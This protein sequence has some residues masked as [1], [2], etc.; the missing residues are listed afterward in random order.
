MTVPIA[1]QIAAVE[2]LGKNSTSN[3]HSL[4]LEAAHQTLLYVHKYG[5]LF[6]AAIEVQRL[7]PEFLRTLIEILKTFEGAIPRV[8]QYRYPPGAQPEQ[9]DA[10]DQLLTQE[11]S[12]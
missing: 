1:D 9:L 12:E 11:G 3:E 5:G 6:R 2:A 7:S 4:A 8:E 10:L